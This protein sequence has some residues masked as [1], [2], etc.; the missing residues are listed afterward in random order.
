M[1][2]ILFDCLVRLGKLFHSFIHSSDLSSAKGMEIAMTLH[3]E[4]IK[5]D[6]VRHMMLREISKFL[7]LTDNNCYCF[8]HNWT[9]KEGLLLSS[10]N[11]VFFLRK[12]QWRCQSNEILSS[13]E[14]TNVDKRGTTH[15]KCR[16]SEKWKCTCE[17]R[18]ARRETREGIQEAKYDS[19]TVSRVYSIVVTEVMTLC[20]VTAV[21]ALKS[22]LKLNG[23]KRN[24]IAVK[25]S[26]NW[27]RKRF[28]SK[29]ERSTITWNVSNLLSSDWSLETL[30]SRFSNVKF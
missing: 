25:L 24:L 14:E 29:L 6:F 12:W 16:M 10:N 13:L 30:K 23:M 19:K 26:I 1:A 9:P 22:C 3:M 15:E 21:N 7:F 2:A 18:G 27:I 5:S 4:L 20:W 28:R 8:I 17:R 11:P